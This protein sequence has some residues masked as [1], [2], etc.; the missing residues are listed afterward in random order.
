MHKTTGTA[1]LQADVKYSNSWLSG[2][3][4]SVILIH[5]VKISKNMYYFY[6]GIQKQIYHMVVLPDATSSTIHHSPSCRYHYSRG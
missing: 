5:P 1:P 6:K 4:A 2:I 3:Q